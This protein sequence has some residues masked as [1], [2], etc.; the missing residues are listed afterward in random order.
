MR[1]APKLGI[2]KTTFIWYNIDVENTAVESTLVAEVAEN[3]DVSN[4]AAE[5]FWC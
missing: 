3:K 1:N 4:V 5:S 2:D